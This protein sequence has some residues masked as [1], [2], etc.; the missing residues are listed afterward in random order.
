[1]KNMVKQEQLIPKAE[2]SLQD[3]VDTISALFLRDQ[4]NEFYKNV[5]E[6][7]ASWQN[8]A[9]EHFSFSSKIS[10]LSRV[11]EDANKKMEKNPDLTTHAQL[12]FGHVGG[13]KAQNF[14]GNIFCN[15]ISP[16]ANLM[17]D[18]INLAHAMISEM[19][20][21]SNLCG[22]PVEKITLEKAITS[23]LQNRLQVNNPA[24]KPKN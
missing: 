18:G 4:I 12:F 15:R 17:L 24:P 14:L 11:Q 5:E 7:D 19:G 9:Q 16:E 6:R 20:I 1:M 3:A 8:A 10:E 21:E 13:N 2:A 22:G 23:V